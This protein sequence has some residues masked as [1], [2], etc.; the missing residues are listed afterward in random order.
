[1]TSARRVRSQLNHYRLSVICPALSLAQARNEIRRVAMDLGLKVAAMRE[2]PAPAALSSHDLPNPWMVT[3]EF[4]SQAGTCMHFLQD[5]TLC[6]KSQP[7]ARVRLDYLPLPALG[8][9]SQRER[10]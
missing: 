1:M 7:Q 6:L 2:M 5:L 4:K 10:C 3:T 9:A 8:P